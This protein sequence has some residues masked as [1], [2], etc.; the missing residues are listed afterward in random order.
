M[1]CQPMKKFYQHTRTNNVDLH[2]K[3]SI[4]IYEERK[5][6]CKD[7]AELMELEN[8]YLGYMTSFMS[9]LRSRSEEGAHGSDMDSKSKATGKQNTAF[10]KM[11]KHEKKA[12]EFVTYSSMVLYSGVDAQQPS[13]S[14][15]PGVCQECGGVLVYDEKESSDICQE[16]GLMD[17]VIPHSV[18]NL[19]YEQTIN[20]NPPTRMQHAYK[21]QTHFNDMLNRVQANT[22]TKIPDHVLSIVQK[23][24]KDT[25]MG[26][27]KVTQSLVRRVLKDL[28]FSKYYDHIISITNWL[29]DKPTPQLSPETEMKFKTMFDQV[30]GPFEK[31]K[32]KDRKNHLSYNYLLNKL[33]RIIGVDELCMYFPLLKSREK[34]AH[35]D[36]IWKKICGELNWKFHPSF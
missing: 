25:R 11:I 15:E 3:E 12:S 5:D 28:K 17:Y 26:N 19:T 30:Q 4:R 1:A 18:D 27:A 22:N 32:P 2:Y 8:D 33:C 7:Q 16:C 6:S 9:Y 36:T 35:Q 10:G 13:K 29:N 31:Y 23:A 20:L 21:R 34:L 24:I 14:F